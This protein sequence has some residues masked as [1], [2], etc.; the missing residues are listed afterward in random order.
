MK[1]PS[2]D[3]RLIELARPARIHLVL[4]VVMS[5]ATAIAIIVQAGALARIIS[6]AFLQ[7]ATLQDVAGDLVILGIA[8]AARSVLSGGAVWSS[9]QIAIITKARLRQRL[10]AHV[11]AL[12][13][14]YTQDQRSGDLTLTLMEGVE[15][16]DGYY[17]DYL[18]GLLNALLVPIIILSAIVPL[19]GLT[20]A[21]LVITAPLIPLFMALIGMAA[22]GLAKHQFL[23]MRF[24]SAHFLDVMQGLT[25]LKL[26]NRSQYQIETIRTITGR[27]REA[28]MRVLRVAFLSAL[29]LEML[30]TLSVAIVAV[31]IGIR[32]LQGG[33][34]FESALFLLVIAPEF[35]LPLRALG[36]KFHTGTEGKAAAESMFQLLDAPLLHPAPAQSVPL[37]PPFTVRFEQV[38]F[39]HE[40]G[41]RGGIRNASF[42][43]EPNQRVVLIGPT[44][45][46]KTTLAQLLLGFL[47]PDSGT[48]SINDVDL[49]QIPPDEWHSQI[50]WVSQK[51]Y[52]FNLSVAD[53]IC[54]G[55]PDATPAKMI[56]AAQAAHAHE[57]ILQLPHG[58]DTV[59][60][61]RG[62]RLSGGQAQRIA[63]ARAFLRNA[64]LII[65]DEATAHLDAKTEA[66]VQAALDVLAHG[67]TVLVIA[68]HL[69]LAA[70]ADHVVVLSNGLIAE[71]GAPHILAEAGGTYAQLLSASVTDVRAATFHEPDEL[72]SHAANMANDDYDALRKI[73]PIAE[74]IRVSGSVLARLL[75]LAR[76]QWPAM[77]L[78]VFLGVLTVGSSVSLLAT[79]AWMISKAGLQPSIADLGVSVVA[80][81][82]FGIARGI[83]RYL[84]RLVSH[85]TTFR[86]LAQAR[87][88]FYRAIEKLAPARL[89]RFRTGDL[90]GRAVDDIES[91][92]NVFLR[93]IAPPL[94]ALLMAALLFAFL[95]LFSWPG[96]LIA[97]TAMLI[98]G[99]V[100][101]VGIAKIAH[102]VGHMRVARRAELNTVLVDAMNGLA[103]ATVYGYIARLIAQLNRT[104]QQLAGTEKRL[105]LLDTSQAG[106]V[107][108]VTQGAALGVLLC[109]IGRVDGIMLA[110]L[111]LATMAAFEAILPLGQAAVQA[112]VNAAAAHRLFEMAD[113]RPAVQDIPNPL[114]LPTN[115][116]L[117]FQHVT[118][119]YD[120][121]EPETPPALNDFTLTI[122]AGARIA[123]V[124]ESG[125]GK[126][127]LA[128]LLARF[129]DYE[130][131][132][133]RLGGV[134][135]RQF[136]AHDV[137]DR[138]GIM[139]Q[140]AYVFNTTLRENIRIGRP[141]ASDAD[142]IAAVNTAQLSPFIA[143]LPNGID[144]IVGEDGT[145]LSAGERQRLALARVLLK[146]SPILV[147]DEPTANLDIVTEQAM[148]RAVLSQCVGRTLILMTHRQAC[149]DEM[150]LIA[151]L[152]RGHVIESIRHH[153]HSQQSGVA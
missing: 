47:K 125:S 88:T 84:E 29:S 99:G 39:S 94:V 115:F 17:R 72:N 134:D 117:A 20:F 127:T 41:E 131:G 147:L 98:G 35:Y 122:P 97:V 68:H 137:R 32:L 113:Q 65:L 104:T 89:S 60:G 81:R 31:E 12:G 15:R 101:P 73:D 151:V 43:I 144:T 77:A 3:Q 58:Y 102:N 90:L 130:R 143:T 10:I 146:R 118:F 67:R 92:Q 74:E 100:I 19:D 25:T 38:S 45:S 148:L 153:A 50:A 52:L 82:F 53:N 142:V 119:G 64:P 57:F 61:E 11:M 128:N 18:P 96:A 1:T 56:A 145:K 34:P 16:L 112:G 69:N 85:D 24:L 91:L 2:L 4:A 70:Q 63:I 87:V 103:D 51:P 124:G 111:A 109:A 22:G 5:M 86:L 126:S 107:V 108:F 138:I 135:L 150:D 27:F 105:A 54:L 7:R 95:G 49:E 75:G 62:L 106:L 23:E 132:D 121:A 110:S 42:T 79:S 8:I 93:A 76:P 48:I 36:A 40:A 80:V 114:P 116:D 21:I 6:R 33:I 123:I 66:E 28:T 71:Q 78:A 141:D 55:W 13:P 44:G 37:K 139:E 26:F 46:G 59:C 136:A 140:R 133:I 83:L 149:L 129:W 120:A 14:T 30:A 152:Q 9:A